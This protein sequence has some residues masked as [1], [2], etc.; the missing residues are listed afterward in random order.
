ML[1]QKE[2]ALQEHLIRQLNIRFGLLFL[3]SFLWLLY[4]TVVA[5][6]PLTVVNGGFEDISGE[7]PVNEFTFGAL[8]G[9]DLYDPNGVAGAG[10]GSS[11]YIG[12][13]RP[14]ETAVPGVFDNFPA[15]APQGERVG[16]AFNVL[17]THGDEY[18]LE[19]TLSDTLQA[20]TQYTLNVQIG[21][22]DSAEAQNGTY[23]ELSGFPGYRVELLA[24]TEVV[25]MDNNSLAGS[26]DDGEF[27]LSTINF[28]TGSSHGQLGEALMIRLI[29]LNVVDGLH[30][31]SHLE[32]DFDDVQL[33]A[34]VVPIPAIFPLMSLLSGCLMLFARRTKS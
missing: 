20:N 28:T 16:I 32:V 3:S 33:S 1:R 9:W 21:N 13:L 15:G 5:A 7:S 34:V 22:I 30:P 27:A 12:T 6:A 14:T 4:S 19:Q 8:N 18:G 10:A 11:F 26:I 24:G 23:F 2:M 17:G 31:M 25:A 29:N